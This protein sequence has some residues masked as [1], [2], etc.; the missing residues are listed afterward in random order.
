MPP[1]EDNSCSELLSPGGESRIRVINV[2]CA[3]SFLAKVSVMAR[4]TRKVSTITA[5]DAAN[6]WECTRLAL[7]GVK[8]V[9][10]QVGMYLLARNKRL[11]NS[12]SKLS[13]GVHLV[14]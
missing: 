5:M 2:N 8:A 4:T 14:D 1:R 10:D 9:R 6:H 3:K 7:A 13:E 11:A 12:P